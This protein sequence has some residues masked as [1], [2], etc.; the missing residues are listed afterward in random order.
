MADKKYRADVISTNISDYIHTGSVSC[1]IS[2]HTT[3]RGDLQNIKRL[4]MP[5]VTSPS[6]CPRF[7]P[8]KVT[9]THQCGEPQRIS[10]A[11]FPVRYAYVRSEQVFNVLF[12][13]YSGATLLYGFDQILTGFVAVLRHDRHL[14]P[15]QSDNH[16]Y[17]NPPTFIVP[18]SFNFSADAPLH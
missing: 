16:D 9:P 11:T 15:L 4:G 13:C 2:S 10:W 18:A 8:T 14:L 17:C 1:I 7:N 12:L 6:T 5:L 3:D